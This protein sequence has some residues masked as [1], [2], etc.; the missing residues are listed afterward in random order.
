LPQLHIGDQWIYRQIE[1]GTTYTRTETITGQERI[2]NND[3]YVEK[4]TFVPPYRGEPE[5][6][7]WRDKATLS[8]V[9]QEYTTVNPSLW[10]ETV[11]R[12]GECSSQ[13]TG[14][15]WPYKVGNV[16]TVSRSCKVT[17]VIDSGNHTGN[18]SASES[19]VTA[20]RVTN[21]EEIEIGS[22]KLTCFKTVASEGGNATFEYWY[23]DKAKA[24]V[25]HVSLDDGFTDELLSYSLR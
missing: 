17:D 15:E 25:K 21:L 23:S 5:L 20:F 2:G 16:F 24:Y 11:K 19:S 3:C 6:T 22:E 13:V 1:E 14:N 12:L 8:V 18:Y 7:Q 9:Q 10:N 4:L